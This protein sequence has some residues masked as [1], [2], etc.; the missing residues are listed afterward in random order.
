MSTSKHQEFQ[1]KAMEKGRRNTGLAESASFSEVVTALVD[2]KYFAEAVELLFG[3]ERNPPLSDDKLGFGV[4][5]QLRIGRYPKMVKKIA[6]AHH[7]NSE[8]VDTK[9]QK[10]GFKINVYPDEIFMIEEPIA[11]ELL[12]A[13]T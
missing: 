9:R 13:M 2:K 10:G 5:V 1:A 12:T 3:S 8:K 11:T 7:W 6:D 4:Y